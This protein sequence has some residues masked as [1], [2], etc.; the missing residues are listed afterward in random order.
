MHSI[1]A[2][3]NRA[4]STTVATR[5]PSIRAHA[6]FR[7]HLASNAAEATQ[8]PQTQGPTKRPRIRIGSHVAI[9]QL[10]EDVSILQAQLETLSCRRRGTATTRTHG[11]RLC[12]QA[13]MMVQTI[14]Q[15]LEKCLVGALGRHEINAVT[16]TRDIE[17]LLQRLQSIH[18]LR[19]EARGQQDLKEDWR[20]QENRQLWSMLNSI[21][22][23]MEAL[24]ARVKGH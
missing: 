15:D 4:D 20:L 22:R 5:L 23:E 8:R 3:L 10:R 24:L 18:G 21:L 17:V 9:K 12:G 2:L 14:N 19:E 7:D 11:V 6:G 1:H 16:L 13:F